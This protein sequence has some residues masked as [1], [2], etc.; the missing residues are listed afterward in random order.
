MKKG[1]NKKALILPI[2][3]LTILVINLVMVSAAPIDLWERWKQGTLENLD[4]KILV[5]VL[6]AIII[7]VLLV[8]IGLNAGLSLLISIPF[9]FLLTAFVTPASVLGIIRSY[10]SLPLTIMTILPLLLFFAL[11]YLSVAK[12]NRTLMTVQLLAWWIYFA[13]VV[14]K[15][16]AFWFTVWGW[17]PSGWTFVNVPVW[18]TEE[19]SYYAIAMLITAILSGLMAIL[20]GFFMNWAL[21]RTMGVDSIAAKKTIADIKTGAK[22]LQELGKTF[23]G[24]K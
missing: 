4:A 10:E 16:A 3:I 8:S 15:L 12:G 14:I 19:A 23:S 6:V 20:N 2:F 17:V 5:L 11:T 21:A 22:S 18:G 9:S 1:I 13:Y 24:Q 7:L